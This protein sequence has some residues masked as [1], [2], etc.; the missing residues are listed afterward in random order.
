M[1]N[2]NPSSDGICN[3]INRKRPKKT[4][5]YNFVLKNKNIFPLFQTGFIQQNEEW[6]QTSLEIWTFPPPPGELISKH[7][8]HAS[9]Q[10]RKS[11]LSL[12]YASRFK[13]HLHSFPHWG[14]QWKTWLLNRLRIRG[15]RS[16]T[17]LF[18]SR[19]DIA[20]RP[21]PTTLRRTDWIQT[22][23]HSCQGLFSV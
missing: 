5:I 7:T 12:R 21:H 14:S 16:K 8:K 18:C 11:N 23:S 15:T 22:N 20:S 4:K 10:R 13:C 19:I 6:S 3:S 2:F 17:P 1:S 9:K